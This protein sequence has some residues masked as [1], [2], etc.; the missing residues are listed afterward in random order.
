MWPLKY[1]GS[2]KHRTNTC[3]KSPHPLPDSRSGAIPNTSE[4]LRLIQAAQVVFPNYPYM[5]NDAWQKWFGRQFLCT[6]YRSS[7]FHRGSDNLVGAFRYSTARAKLHST[8]PQ[9]T[10]AQITHNTGLLWYGSWSSTRTCS[11]NQWAENS[12][13]LGTLERAVLHPPTGTWVVV[14]LPR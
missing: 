11:F 12:F 1:C 8:K 13:T 5:T 14:V 2:R 6:A 9:Y 4:T 3:L 10:L 7:K